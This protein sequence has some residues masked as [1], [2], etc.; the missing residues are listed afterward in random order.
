[1]CVRSRNCW[2]AAASPL[3]GYLADRVGRKP[4]ILMS[5]AVWSAVTWAT[6]HVR[7]FPELLVCRGQSAGRVPCGP[8][9]PEADDPDESRGMVRRHLG[10]RPCAYVPGIA[11]LPRPVRWP[12]TLRTASAG[13]R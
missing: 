1:M 11:G 13:S 9:R 2:S 8:R 4:M 10:D 6:G 3:A 7:T 12:G 5:L